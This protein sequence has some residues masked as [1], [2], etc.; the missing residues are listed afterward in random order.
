MGTRQERKE[1]WKLVGTFGVDAGLCWIGDPCYVMGTGAPDWARDWD[2][3]CA[4]LGKREEAQGDTGITLFGFASSAKREDFETDEDYTASL[5]THGCGIACSTGYG[6]GTY[7][8]WAKTNAEGRVVAL[9]ICLDGQPPA[10][11]LEE[12]GGWND[13]DEGED[14]ADAH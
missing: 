7:P 2:R 13:Q 5:K 1:G 12:C 4:E 10:E 11:I 9:H 6:D 8:V 14:E 3:F